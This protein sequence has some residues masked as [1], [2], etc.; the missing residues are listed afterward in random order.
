MIGIEVMNI[1]K[2]DW[3][4]HL[5]A[6][7]FYSLSSPVTV[8]YLL[9]QMAS[10]HR[11]RSNCIFVSSAFLKISWSLKYARPMCRIWTDKILNKDNHKTSQSPYPFKYKSTSSAGCRQTGPLSDPD[12]G[13][14]GCFLVMTIFARTPPP[15]C[16]VIP[17]SRVWSPDSLSR[18]LWDV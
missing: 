1:E 13:L 7:W 16:L 15:A 10:N 14:R 4:N 11:T 8:E 6:H 18:Q 12:P 3:R 2:I 17:T 9:F 5:Y